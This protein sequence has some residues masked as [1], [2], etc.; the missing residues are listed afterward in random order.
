MYAEPID[1]IIW[2]WNGTLLADG[3]ALIEATIEA[4]VSAGLGPVS[5]LDYQTRHCQPIPAFY[6][7][8]IGRRLSG[9]EQGL[10][11]TGFQAAYLKRRDGVVLTQD[12]IAALTEWRDAGGGQ[13][14]LSMYPHDRLVPLVRKFG[15]DPFFTRVDG[16]VGTESN[17]KAPHLARHLD[18]L[19]VST[20]RVL[21]VGD[22]VDDAR[23]ARECGVSCVMYHAG[24][25]SL[26]ALDHFA[27]LGVPVV[28][29]LREAVTLAKDRSLAGPA[30]SRNRHG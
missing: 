17:R 12:A 14:L 11:D 7:S 27:E 20:D 13:S 3:S 4:F 15:I 26:H 6:D 25:D 1:H 2:D 28:E 5:R 29:S 8:L 24:P 9:V 21:L 18:R 23:A 22:S 30:D 10:L 16:M 19:S